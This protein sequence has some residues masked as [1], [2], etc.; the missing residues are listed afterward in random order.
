MNFLRTL[1]LK[2][3]ILGLWIQRFTTVIYNA[4]DVALDTAPIILGT[5]QF[6]T[7]DHRRIAN[8][9][10]QHCAASFQLKNNYFDFRRE[11]LI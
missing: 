1:G 10:A 9:A 2:P 5:A 4:N 8:W 11:R 7:E 3:A 6:Y